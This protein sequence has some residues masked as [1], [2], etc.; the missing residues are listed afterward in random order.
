M[1]RVVHCILLCCLCASLFAQRGVRQRSPIYTPGTAFRPSGW[2]IGGGITY[3]LPEQ[4]KQSLTAY[5]ND[6]EGGDTLF[7]G[8]YSRAGKIGAYL[9]FG[10]HHFISDRLL[11]HHWDYGV[12][13]KLLR[14]REQFNGTSA[15]AAAPIE[16]RSKYGNLFAGAFCNVSNVITLAD[17][18]YL[19]NGIG[20]NADFSV[21]R[22]LSEGPS[23]GATYLY[24]GFFTAQLH[25]KLSYVWRPESGIYVVP[26]IE[27]P[28]ITAFPWD[29]TKATLNYFTDRSR[30]FIICLRIQWLSKH[31]DRACEG[32][33]GQAPSL[34]KGGRHTKNDLFGDDAKS[35]KKSKKKVNK[36][37]ERSD[38]KAQR[39]KKRKD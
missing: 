10:R 23:Y 5:F 31:P 3:M 33:P 19:M 4:R 35:M 25:Y 16:S 8:D 24:P 7:D 32:Q 2:L 9:E 6:N 22:R 38:K 13:G 20:V 39:K 12:H 1:N 27:T 21:I 30:P 36:R 37:Q 14:G 15:N 28:L 29:N 18:H 17:R 11:I 26:S 34:D